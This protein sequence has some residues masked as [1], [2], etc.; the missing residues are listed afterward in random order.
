MQVRVAVAKVAKYAVAESGD[1]VEVVERPRGGLS[2]VIV[3]GQGTGWPAK[4]ISHQVVTKAAGLIADGARD[5]AVVRAVHDHLHAIRAGKVSAT[6]C[7][8]S[9]DLEAGSLIVSRNTNAPVLVCRG[10]RAT[11][12]EADVEPIG[13]HRMMRPAID[14]F[15]IE[16]GIIAVGMTDGIIH[17]GRRR[18]GSGFPLEEAQEIVAG[19]PVERLQ[20]AAQ[21][22]L[23]RAIDRDAG[24]PAD[25]M[26]VALIGISR[27]P[28][29]HRIRR[30]D[31]TYPFG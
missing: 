12:L 8:L 9:A 28:V 6:L 31:V 16:P 7:L 22:L 11:W 1:T 24:Q 19:C 5:G 13:V 25:D 14:H 17:A 26:A 10:G 4:R 29:E 15:P 30:L 20:E 27:E 18:G 23:Q 21:A 2:V 3:D